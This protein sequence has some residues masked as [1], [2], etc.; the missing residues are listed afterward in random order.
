M[1]NW[2]KPLFE[3]IV[4][5][6]C[7]L[8]AGLGLAWLPL[9]KSVKDIGILVFCGVVLV[10]ALFVGARAYRTIWSDENDWDDEATSASLEVRQ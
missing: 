2:L 1:K 6:V 9:E 3:W 4:L 7:A 10:W 5:S 8:A